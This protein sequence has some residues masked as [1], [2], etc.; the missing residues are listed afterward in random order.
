M[1]WLMRQS[2]A[3]PEAVALRVGKSE[4]TWASMEFQTSRVAAAL[5]LA[6]LRSGSRVAVLAANGPSYVALVHAAMWTGTTLV[7]LNPRLA[8]A[9]LSEQLHES[10]ADLLVIDQSAADRS[11]DLGNVRF[12]QLEE[13]TRSRSV[14]A[15]PV[16]HE[17]A[18]TLLFTSGTTGQPK[19]VPLTWRNHEASAIA[20]ALN[21]GINRRDDWLCC[22]P[23]YHVGGLAILIRSVLY[24]TTVTL[25]EEFDTDEVLG[26]LAHQSTIVSLVPT[27]LQRLVDRAGS[28]EALAEHLRNG[29][30]RIILLGGGA[31]D[32]KL[33][34]SCLAAGLP[35]VQTYGMTECAS[36]IATLPPERASDK[37]GSCG[38]PV[39]D[40]SIDIRTPDGAPVEEG[41]G[42][43]WVRGPMV[44]SGYLNERT[45]TRPRFSAGWFRTGDWGELDEEGYLWVHGRHD[46][47]II[48][49]GE[50]VSPGQVESVIA[51]HPRVRDVAVFGVPD[52]EWGERIA[53]AIVADGTVP[54][55]ELEAHC[56]SRLAGFQTPRRWFVVEKIPRTSLGKLQRTRLTERFARLS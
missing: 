43:I 34:R 56:R 4:I 51:Q 45:E 20:S 5:N 13:L 52:N 42:V 11:L 29:R 24:G 15:G 30:L 39:W 46:E 16:Q 33:I 1:N 48:S 21:L 38:L 31:P 55:D 26:K 7:P 53:A 35:I 27:M 14:G 40:A 37:I 54:T 17:N 12:V 32:P 2:T 19:I 47:I 50:N 49:G 8:D 36:Q 23:L 41:P 3:R 28:A 9:T 18:A 6:G 25:L 10:G 22:L 44:T